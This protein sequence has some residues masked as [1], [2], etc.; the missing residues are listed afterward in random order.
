MIVLS[1]ELHKLISQARNEGE[2]DEAK[3]RFTESLSN[4]HNDI[5]KFLSNL[6][7]EVAM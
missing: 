4:H 7:V 3:K 2:E 5:L 1:F 6:E